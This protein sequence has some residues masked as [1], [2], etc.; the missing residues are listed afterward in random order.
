LLITTIE[1]EKQRSQLGVIRSSSKSLLN[2]IND[3][4]D[5]S[6]IEAGKMKIQLEP[7]YFHSVISEIEKVF[8][9]KASEKGIRF[10]VENE[11][12]VPT[13]LMLDE[14]R[15]RQILFN[16]VDNAIKFTEQGHV[17]LIIDRIM[18][19]QNKLDLVISI[20]DTGIG[21]P[22]DQYEHI[23]NAFSQLKA[24][25]Q[26]KHIGTG[27]GL[28]ITRRLVELLGGEITLLSE[29]CKGSTFRVQI[30]DISIVN[31]GKPGQKEKIFDIRNIHFNKACILIVD[32]NAE[33][34]KLLVDLL[35]SSPLE[36]FEAGNGKEALELVAKHRP[37]LILMDLR[38]PVMSGY[39][40]TTILKSQEATREIPVV[41]LSASPKIVI[42]GHTNKEIFDDFIMKPV[43]I[44]EFA[45]ILKKYLAYRVSGKEA[46]ADQRLKDKSKMNLSKREKEKV[47][48][49][50][51]ILEKQYMPVY[52]DL[53]KKQVISQIGLFGKNLS[54]LGLK[55]ND[56]DLAFY[57]KEIFN[58][59]EN[60]DVELL[61]EKLKIF[62]A[63]IEK[64][65]QS[66]K[67]KI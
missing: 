4:L 5:L 54:E 30:P 25:P 43:I 2:L 35:D 31:E 67:V 51:D 23:F 55:A 12:A 58:D 33:N 24:L 1:D 37:D 59:A 21:I 22:A 28:T 65:N 64:L 11:K 32:D 7:V 27:L 50:V 14:T 18:K 56:E 60:F 46:A 19:G 36:I 15:L 57:G 10:F 13:L 49:L 16:L 52:R 66:L 38:M 47:R 29:P 8:V 63:L 3:I 20:E 41:A 53:L 6:K 34:R 26:K 39:E 48:E 9:Q 45:E 42:N 62:P 44:S 61:M 40:A 17:I